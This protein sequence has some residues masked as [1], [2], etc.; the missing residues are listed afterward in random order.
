[1]KTLTTVALAAVLLLLPWAADRAQ[2]TPPADSGSHVAVGAWHSEDSGNPEQVSEYSPTGSGPE[3]DVRLEN[4]APGSHFLLSAHT[5]GVNTQDMNLTFDVHRML[6]SRTD[7]TKFVHRLPHD[8]LSYMNAVASPKVLQGT[9]LSPYDEY[10]VNYSLL[11]SRL[12]FQHPDIPRLTLG[13]LF[14]DQHRDGNHQSITLGH[15]SGCH[16]YG[17]TRGVDEHVYDIGFKAELNLTKAVVALSYTERSLTNG[18]DSVFQLYPRSQHPLLHTDIFSN[19]V[20]YDARNGILPSDLQLELDKRTTKL[21]VTAPDLA[22]F[23]LDAGGV[24][25]TT[26]NRRTD[27]SYDYEGYRLSTARR[28]GGHKK[29]SFRW[30]SNYYTLDSDPYYINTAEPVAAAGPHIGRTYQDVY[31]VNPDYWRYSTLDRRVYDS[32]LDLGYRFGKKAGSLDLEWLYR[33]EDRDN[34]TVLGDSTKTTTNR[35]RLTYRA[36][37]WK[38]GQFRGTYQ[39]LEAN[40]TYGNPNGTCTTYEA[41]PN[42]SAF[43]AAQYYS[44][45]AAR[46]SDPSMSPETEDRYSLFLSHNFGTKASL[47]AATRWSS[48]DNREGDNTDWSRDQMT[49]DLTFWHAPLSNLEWFAN[50]AIQRAESDFP[51]C[52]ALMDG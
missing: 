3:F 16:V 41:P 6:R 7:F 49:A 32:N 21:D 35:Y 17:Q 46:V 34:F 51:T 25:S 40:H 28:F 9:D 19:R 23:V 31:G 39:R 48:A 13:L 29:W 33:I 36:K 15:C 5:V 4:T 27:V 20:Q 22:G 1:M 8:S 37:P 43:V 47:T 26:E 12:E 42:P 2:V 14:R 45:R 11:E 38:G 52:I 50:V 10:K 18:V 30:R 24:W 44:W